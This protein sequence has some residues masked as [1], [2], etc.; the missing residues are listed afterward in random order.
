MAYPIDDKLVVAVASS[1][2]FDLR[3]SDTVYRERADQEYRAFQREN[4][5]HSPTTG[6]GVPLVRRLAALTTRPPE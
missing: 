3:E 5:N 2:P 6:S 4:E 1:A